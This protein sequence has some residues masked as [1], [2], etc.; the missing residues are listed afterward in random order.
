MKGW[1]IEKFAVLVDVWAPLCRHCEFIK[2]G[3]HRACLYTV[4]AVYAVVRANIILVGFF[5]C[6]YAVYWTYCQ[7][8][9]VFYTHARFSDYEGHLYLP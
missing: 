8:C 6:V 9:G 7:A 5:V 3:L 2:D 1:L 4:R